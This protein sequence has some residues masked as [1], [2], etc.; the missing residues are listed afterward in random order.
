MADALTDVQDGAI[1]NLDI[2]MPSRFA[3]HIPASHEVL[4]HTENAILSMGSAPAK[5]QDDDD[6]INVG[7]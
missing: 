4:L 1:V 3:T 2:G 5:G 7:K 6:R